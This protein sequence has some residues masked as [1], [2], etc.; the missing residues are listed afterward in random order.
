MSFTITTILF[1]QSKAENLALGKSKPKKLVPTE[2]VV[3][4]ALLTSY[5]TLGLHLQQMG[6][7]CSE[8]ERL[9]ANI[10][11]NKAQKRSTGI[12]LFDIEKALN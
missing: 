11:K 10:T 4:I 9:V 6:L 7:S 5:T 2:S 12:V 8:P 3:L 1:S